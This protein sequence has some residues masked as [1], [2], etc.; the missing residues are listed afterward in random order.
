[1]LHS[2]SVS[3]YLDDFLSDC[4]I[5]SLEFRIDFLKPT[6]HISSL[7][8]NFFQKA[9][10]FFVHLIRVFFLLQH[11]IHESPLPFQQNIFVIDFLFQLLDSRLLVPSAAAL[12]NNCQFRLTPSDLLESLVQLYCNLLLKRCY[13]LLRAIFEEVGDFEYSSLLLI[14]GSFFSLQQLAL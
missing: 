11:F 8:I 3:S 13:E 5:L 12:N 4:I 7:S 10:L 2:L 1:M 6:A 14:L 9:Q